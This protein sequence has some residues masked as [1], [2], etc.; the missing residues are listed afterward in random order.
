MFG[1]L[2]ATD[3]RI[4]GPKYWLFP[5]FGGFDSGPKLQPA[6]ILSENTTDMMGNHEKESR[7]QVVAGR[8]LEDLADIR[9]IF[10]L[11]FCI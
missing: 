7:L 5:G 6:W 10:L 4:I 2:V 8:S 1:Y 3:G 11:L 9:P